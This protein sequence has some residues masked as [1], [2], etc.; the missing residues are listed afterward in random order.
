MR[1]ALLL[2]QQSEQSGTQDEGSGDA[3]A[4]VH[5]GGGRHL[6]GQN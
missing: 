5:E 3:N 4:S 6:K 2:V 1:I